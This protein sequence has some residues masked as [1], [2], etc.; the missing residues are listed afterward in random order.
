[1]PVKEKSNLE[2]FK[3]N[4]GKLRIKHKLPSFEELNEDF[5]IERVAEVETDI[6]IREVRKFLSDKFS[7]YL[8]FIE[9]ILNPATAPMFVFSMVRLIGNEEKIKLSNAYKQLAKNEVIL[10]ELDLKFSEEKE[11]EF[12]KESFKTWQELKKDILSVMVFVKKNW[13]NKQE[14]NG[15]DYF[16]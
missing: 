11:A 16:G 15:K 13:D 1:M 2:K 9:A 7:N 8:R 4:Y 3:E 12:I 6:L 5:Q 10:I 14:V